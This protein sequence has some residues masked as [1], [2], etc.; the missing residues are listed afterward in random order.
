MSS[1]APIS[2][3]QTLREAFMK[4]D[5]DDSFGY[6]SVKVNFK[7]NQFEVAQYVERKSDDDALFEAMGHEC[8]PKEHRYF[9]IR[10]PTAKQK[11]GGGGGGGGSNGDDAESKESGSLSLYILIHFAPDLS[12]VKQRMVYAASRPSLKAFLGASSFSEDYHCSSTDDLNLKTIVTARTL[13]HDIDFRSEAEIEKEQ[14]AMESVATSATSAVMKSLPI[15]V[16]DSAKNAIAR[17]QSGDSKCVFLTLSNDTQSIQGEEKKADGL[18]AL[19]MLLNEKEPKYILFH[20]EGRAKGGDEQKQQQREQSVFGYFCPEKA[21]RKKRFTFSTAKANVIAYCE[22]IGLA[23]DAKVEVTAISDFNS[24]YMDYHV[25]PVV[26]QKKEQFAMPK[27]PKARKKKKGK[28]K[29]IDMDAL[30][31]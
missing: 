11:G 30:D 15:S 1:A 21:D 23:F 19:R 2:G 27:G 8:R 4:A 25:F 16:E 5:G 29:K 31:E 17:Y 7:T 3:D 22:S 10:D 24:E 12:P 14:A 6:L 9:I 26:H 18:S 28:K 13:H 20:H